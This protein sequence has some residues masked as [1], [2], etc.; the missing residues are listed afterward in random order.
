MSFNLS[1]SYD[2]N[3]SFYKFVVRIDIESIGK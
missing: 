1:R 3:N 2:D